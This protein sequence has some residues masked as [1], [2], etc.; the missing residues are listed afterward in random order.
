MQWSFKT[1]R[2]T[3][4]LLSYIFPS[5]F[6]NGGYYFSESLCLLVFLV[7]GNL[8]QRRLSADDMFDDK[9][10]FD[11]NEFFDMAENALPISGLVSSSL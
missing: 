6:H 4:I 2:E 9:K 7:S 10:K 5:V 11:I 1:I 8:N 3:T